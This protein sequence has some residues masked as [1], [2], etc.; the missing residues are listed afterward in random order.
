MY[1]FNSLLIFVSRVRPH[2]LPAVGPPSIRMAFV[3]TIRLL[4]S[5]IRGLCIH[6][7]KRFVSFRFFKGTARKQISSRYSVYFQLA[8]WLEFYAEALEL[9][10]WTSSTV[11]KAKRDEASGKWAV[12]VKKADGS[13]RVFNVDHLVFAIGLGGGI[14]NIPDIPGRVRTDGGSI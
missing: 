6:L 7:L 1:L 4:V 2:A 14:P 10:F 3:L 11:T 9:D 12:T 5:P 13:E 8:D